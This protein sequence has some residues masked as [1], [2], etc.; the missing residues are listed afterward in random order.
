MAKLINISEDAWQ[1]I[2]RM[3]KRQDKS[4]AEVVKRWA[5]AEIQ[6]LP[7][8]A[9][10]DEWEGIKKRLKGIIP[11]DAMLGLEKAVTGICDSLR[12]AEIE[13]HKKRWS[14][15]EPKPIQPGGCN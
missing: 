14:G 3:A 7:S 8:D 12:D 6:K 15:P 1:A 2:K 11:D 13:A 4:M 10:Y 9:L 5:V